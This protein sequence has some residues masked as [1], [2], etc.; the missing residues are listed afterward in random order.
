MFLPFFG[1]DG[2][3]LEC[4]IVPG[5]WAASSSLEGVLGNSKMG[6]ETNP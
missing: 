3:Y 2:S 1:G 4:G 5:P 6:L